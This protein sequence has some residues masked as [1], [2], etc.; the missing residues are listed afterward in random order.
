MSP[1][2]PGES[3]LLRAGH[4]FIAHRQ[5]PIIYRRQSPHMEPQGVES[6]E[7]L[8]NQN[9]LHWQWGKGKLHRYSYVENKLKPLW[10]HFPGWLF[11]TLS[12]L[13]LSSAVLSDVGEAAEESKNGS[14]VFGTLLCTLS[15]Q[16]TQLPPLPPIWA[17]QASHWLIWSS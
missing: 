3:Q 6:M 10:S 13:I 2:Y 9:Q 8:G 15:L 17:G 5:D 4:H 1:K 16:H 14:F 11:R 7:R 12:Y